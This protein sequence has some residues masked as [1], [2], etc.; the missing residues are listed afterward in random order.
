VTRF[1]AVLFDNGNTLFHKPSRIPA[2]VHL[3]AELGTQ[4]DEQRAGDAWAAVKSHKRAIP[5]EALVFGRNRSAAGHR[6]YYMECYAPL[7]SVAPG[8]AGAFYD[9]FKTNPETMIPYPDTGE[10]LS[11]LKAAGL[12]VG[13]VSN[14]GWNIREGYQQAGF[15][16]C[17]DTYVLSFEHGVAKP[18][19][20]LFDVACANLD[21][22]PRHTL[23]VGNNGVA[24]SGAA[25]VGCT[26]LVLPEVDRGQSRGLSAV[27]RLVGIEEPSVIGPS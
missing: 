16:D 20:D 19:H 17:I 5:D 14:T 15:G 7:E 6:R 22:D 24:D 27:L 11:A 4:I 13:I 8:L 12:R 9:H 3:A 18:A 25:K 23:M 26:C 10:V 1:T 21:V 2:L